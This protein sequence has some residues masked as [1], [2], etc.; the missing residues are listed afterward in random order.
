[1]TVTAAP[2]ARARSLGA[3]AGTRGAKSMNLLA[4]LTARLHA[5]LLAALL[6]GALFAQ[7]PGGE[8]EHGEPPPPA[9]A[10]IARTWILNEAARVPAALQAVVFSRFSSSSSDSVS[11]PFAAD[12]SLRRQSIEVGG[13]LGLGRGLSFQITGVQSAP[14]VLDAGGGQT[15]GALV[16][17]RWAA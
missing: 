2:R 16:G 14:A 8:I 15:A 1:H 10:P 13:E 4:S 7:S 17:L 3:L 11:R 5:Y 9:P 12:L 6:P